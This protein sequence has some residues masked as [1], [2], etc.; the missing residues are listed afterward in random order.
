MLMRARYLTDSQ[1]QSTKQRAGAW[2]TEALGGRGAGRL[3]VRI[4]QGSE[5]LFYFRYTDAQRKQRAIAL[6]RY[7]RDGAA[8]LTLALARERAGEL[9]K[10][11][12]AGEREL[13]AYLNRQRQAVERTRAAEDSERARL[14][15]EAQRG[16]L[17]KLLEAYADHL[18]KR[19]ERS[20]RDAR[21]MFKRNVY[22]AWSEIADTKAS[23]L[24]P[25]EITTILRG[26]V[27]R[28]KGRTAA[29]LRSYVRAAYAL[30]MKSEHDA[31]APAMLRTFGIASNPAAAT[32]ALSEFS[33]ARDRTL[34]RVELGAFLRKL[35]EAPPG[36][37]KDALSLALL[38]GGQRPAQLLRLAP[39]DVDVAGG[40]L[41]LRDGKGARRQ[42]R[43]HM[44]P[45]PAAAMEILVPRLAIAASAHKTRRSAE[46]PSPSKW[47]FSVH[48]NRS[49]RPETLTTLTHDLA[50][51]MA[52]DEMLVEAKASQGP[53][54][55]RDIRRTCETML[56]SLGVSR[57]VRAQLQ[58][59]GL[60]GVQQRHY[61]RHDYMQEKRAA[62]E[63]WNRHL[64]ALERGERA[65][66]D[67]V[68][69]ARP[70]VANAA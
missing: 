8:G 3:I 58:S 62:L 23:L 28:G 46:E 69:I 38:L 37:A 29:K 14:T 70:R 12:Q 19:N 4:A 13:H 6:G 44:L 68:P 24:Q 35:H 59:H 47:V 33:R 54:G 55:L 40:C 18:S 27:E 49:T 34:N 45:I 43:A 67:V 30:A 22:Q 2:L 10:V 25:R 61:D 60:G 11:Y 41:M 31:T 26:V 65:T 50:T 56:A 64:E 39:T 1:L 17:R 16:T 63:L 21:S 15:D 20:A 51:A 53:F 9:S 5:R 52:R 48:G 66:A 42:P 7:D 32:A 57:E 36:P